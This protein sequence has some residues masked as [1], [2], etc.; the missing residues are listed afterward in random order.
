MT[1]CNDPIWVVKMFSTWARVVGGDR[2]CNQRSP[3]DIHYLKL[4]RCVRVGVM[5]KQ[6]LKPH[7]MFSSSLDVHMSPNIC[8]VPAAVDCE[9]TY[10]ATCRRT[11]LGFFWLFAE[12][13]DCLPF[14]LEDIPIRL[15]FL[16]KTRRGKA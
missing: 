3:P 6:D 8:V 13:F 12:G 16:G 14:T 10:D 4:V 9:M 11:N 7:R 1:V 5:T 2:R 15:S